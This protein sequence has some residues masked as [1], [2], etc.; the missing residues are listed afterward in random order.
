MKTLFIDSSKIDI[1]YIVN[2]LFDKTK[3]GGL[4]IPDIIPENA[5]EDLLEN[6]S[7]VKK[8]FW[9]AQQKEGNVIQEIQ[10]LY[11]EELN[12]NCLDRTFLTTINQ[13]KDEY[14]EIYR[15]ISQRAQFEDERFNSLGFHYYPRNTVGIS[16]HRDYARDRDL[17]SIFVIKGNAP[18]YVCENR[19]KKGSILLNS[20]PGS[21][22]LLRAAR[23][24]EE[25][26]YRPFHYINK[27]SEERFSLIVRRRKC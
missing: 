21:L 14:S 13:F 25:Q 18:F 16:P 2:E 4:S 22:I 27:V 12:E 11:L 8:Y 17:I 15:E 19:D 26:K 10:C 23:N 9:H 6:V 3:I 24:D 5:R 1:E 20:S 7:L